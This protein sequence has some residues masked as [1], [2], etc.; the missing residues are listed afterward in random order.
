MAHVEDGYGANDTLDIVLSKL[1][2][3]EGG[4][5]IV[6][7][8]SKCESQIDITANVTNYGE[9]TF[10][11]TEIEIIV[12]GLVVDTIN[13]EFG[14][15]YLVD[16]DILIPITE[17]IQQFDNQITLNLLRVNEE[18]DAVLNNNTAMISTDLDS[19]HDYIT[20]II[21]A[22][23]YPQETSWAIYDELNNELI[24][25]GELSP[26]DSAYAQEVCVDYTSCLSLTIFD[27]YGDG[28]CCEY[29][30]GDFLLTNS[31]SEILFT[32]N[33]EFGS[34]AIE[35]FC[36]NGEG[37][38]F[39]TD[40]ETTLASNEEATDGTITINPIGGFAPYE[41]SIDGG[42]TFVSNNAFTNLAPSDYMIVVRDASKTCFQEETIT[43][44]Y[45]ILDSINDIYLGN[46]KVYPNPTRENFIIEIDESFEVLRDINIE[47]YDFLG[48]LTQSNTISRNSQN[49]KTSLS[50]A[51]YNSG[52]YIVK[53][54]N[55]NFEVHFKVI[56]I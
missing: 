2:P 54:Y 41:F 47:I 24:E 56:K 50:L 7:G 5:T 46:I 17:N 20:I 38:T 29:G 6:K 33:G 4:I 48:R 51:E 32:N 18:Q 28:I 39:T 34:Q 43:V 25:T 31:N 44:D 8:I 21:N 9:S 35:L 52:S 3:L 14:I 23:N 45:D 12:N 53:C 26:Q 36:P 13:Y 37:C 42:A 1:H 30:I 11:D 27:S 19:T 15:P 10:Y 16:V 55:E 22:D 49:L 40:I